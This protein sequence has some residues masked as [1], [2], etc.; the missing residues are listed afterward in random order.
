MVFFVSGASSNRRFCCK[1]Y[2]YTGA[3][4]AYAIDDYE[5]VPV[6]LCRAGGCG[7]E[8]RGEHRYFQSAKR[9]GILRSA[10]L[11]CADAAAAFTACC[12]RGGRKL[13]TEYAVSACV[14]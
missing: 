14:S 2:K 9:M 10:R 8:S 3:W 13:C 5:H 6:I 4:N 12:E 7:V 1:R 11:C